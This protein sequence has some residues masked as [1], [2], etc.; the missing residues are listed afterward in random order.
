MNADRSAAPPG[1]ALAM[2]R[3]RQHDRAFN[4]KGRRI[5]RTTILLALAAPLVLVC[6]D[7]NAPAGRFAPAMAGAVPLAGNAEEPQD[8]G[9]VVRRVWAGPGVDPLGTPTPDGSYLTFT[10]WSTGDLAVRDMSNGETRHLT[11]E[12]DSSGA[13]TDGSVVSPDGKRVAFSW[14]PPDGRTAELRIIGLD[15][16][17]MSIPFHREGDDV[18]WAWPYAWSPD[19]QQIAVSLTEDNRRS[20][21]LVSAETGSVRVV[22]EV[23]ARYPTE[24]SFSPDS[25]SIVYD[26]EVDPQSEQRDIFLLPLDGGREIRLV[27]NAAD[28]F[29]LGWVPDTDYVLFS[30]DRTGTPCAWVLRVENGRPAGE[31]VLVKSDL[32]R[33]YP[34]GFTSDGDF[35]YG[36]GI[37]SRTVYTATLDVESGEVLSQ[38]APVDPRRTGAMFW[39]TWSPDGRYL[40]WLK[41]NGNTGRH[42]ITVRSMETGETRE[43]RPRYRRGSVARWSPDGSHWLE[44]GWDGNH[45]NLLSLIDVRTGETELLRKFDGDTVCCNWYDWSP[46]G[47]TVYYKADLRAEYWLASMDVETGTERILYKVEQPFFIPIWNSVSP[48]GRE[49]AFWLFDLNERIG[50]LLVIPTTGDPGK[51]EPREIVRLEGFANTPPAAGVAWT[52]DG[53]HL[54]FIRREG[55][56]EIGR[57]WRVPATGGEPEPLGFARE[58][59]STL[60]DFHPD[61]RT[62]AFAE[63]QG[64]MEIWVMENYLP[65]K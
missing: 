11:E 57:L 41:Q 15:G 46:D 2:P 47:R 53:R 5:M 44:T 63:G 52:P 14:F 48:D 56:T 19:G 64:S 61:G 31:P 26:L 32:W 30:S 38:P 12:G 7:A 1:T 42:T 58:G 22:K 13:Y 17:G 27:E 50:Q 9:L 43:I 23:D 10:D 39:P 59:M 51:V 40:A 24:I 34:M 45:R 29:L 36:I 16:T 6:S 65:R 37:G 54:L 49:M 33:A 28:D 60:P 25:R 21:A 55:D 62:L 4:A 8:T 3:S 20:I 35:Y 18:A